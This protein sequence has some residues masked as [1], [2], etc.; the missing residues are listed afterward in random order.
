[1][2]A[3]LACALSCILV[4]FGLAADAAPVT[5]VRGGTLLEPS[6]GAVR[7]NV[8]IVIED[9]RVREIA[10]AVPDGAEVID[11]SDKVVAPG[12]IDG[13]THVLLQGDATEVEYDEQVLG[14]SLPYRALRASRA[15]R[16]SLEHGFTTLR[17]VGNE[18]ADI[19]VHRRRRWFNLKMLKN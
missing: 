4:A 9:G 10:D 19:L 14:E 18:G 8:V 12:F 6:T 5:A 17:D 3:R 2:S 11:L 1:M 7:P 15:M 16:I 13:H